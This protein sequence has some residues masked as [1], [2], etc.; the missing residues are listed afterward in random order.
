MEVF[1]TFGGTLTTLF[2]CALGIFDYGWFQEHPSAL[3]ETLLTVYLIISTVIL[4]N[5]LIAILSQTYE[6]LSSH[7]S[8]Q[9]VLSNA[10]FTH[11]FIDGETFPPPLSWISYLLNALC[12][13]EAYCWSK[14]CIF[15]FLKTTV[16]GV[17]D[18]AETTSIVLVPCLFYDC[19]VMTCWLFHEVDI[20]SLQFKRKRLDSTSFVR[21]SIMNGLILLGDFLF[22]SLVLPGA[23]ACFAFLYPPL[24]W[25][26][27]YRNGRKG[28]SGNLKGTDEKQQD[29]EQFERVLNR[30]RFVIMSSCIETSQDEL[31]NSGDYD[32]WDEPGVFAK[33]LTA[34]DK[35]TESND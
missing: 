24:F 16:F 31:M 28:K 22:L 21:N 29:I 2:G 6:D 8:Q 15:K 11:S 26:V 35:A 13:I 7:K 30:Q 34:Y 4:L 18:F 27:C 32:A 10:K 25:I 17:V 20:I 33:K 14:G 12:D 3:G 5:L 9:W 23:V 1:S 19:W